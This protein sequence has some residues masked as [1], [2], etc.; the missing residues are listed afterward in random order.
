MAV[1]T[2]DVIGFRRIFVLFVT[3][4]LLPAM[5]MSGFA[6]VAIANQHRSDQQRQR[7]RGEEGLAKAEAAFAATI[8]AADQ[9]MREAAVRSPQAT[10]PLS[11]ASVVAAGHPVGA[12]AVLNPQG[13][14]VGG[15]PPL[16]PLQTGL[17]STDQ[18]LKALADSLRPGQALQLDMDTEPPRLISAQRTHEGVTVF[19]EIDPEALREAVQKRVKLDEGNR[20][21]I[22]VR[23]QK[24]SVGSLDQWLKPA[25]QPGGLE[26][27][28]PVVVI[29]QRRLAAPFDRVSFLIEGAPTGTRTTTVVMVMLVV[30]F[31]TLLT[32]GVVL[33][34]R[35]IWQE[36]KL[37]RLK[38]DFVSHVSHELR[39]P[40][41]SIRM[42]IETL[43][44]GRAQNADEEAECLELL[45]RETERLSEMIERV[46]GY[47]R[48]QS[49]R[50]AFALVPVSAEE[51]I[52][53]AI[54]AFRAQLIGR[55]A[56]DLELRT[57]V[58]PDLPPV[59]ADPEAM[60]EALLNLIGNAYK[61]TGAKKRIC[62]YAKRGRRRVVLGVLDN[63][64]GL[65]KSEHGRI[66]DRF[67]QAGNLLTRKSKGSG[68][69]LAITRG[70]VE[71]Q[72]GRIFVQSEEGQGS[73]FYIELK[74]A[75]RSLEEA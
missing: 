33:T 68:L 63:G 9:A 62:V 21:V 58:E 69:G 73:D 47:A 54:A 44:L 48:L 29:A 51:L 50:R 35:L 49:G 4:V 42:F 70:I 7:E 34:S 60:T 36:A 14:L 17:L 41:T 74:E 5:L 18:K 52:D 15:V 55:P 75:P 37:S 19:Y 6:V 20:L 61:Y 66:F 32:I 67:Y 38:T 11:V 13:E 16:T 46:L 2:R 64:P 45:G 56:A 59:L 72:G 53:D 57:E 24:M 1:T 43:R 23:S 12:W 28:S 3:L 31:Y 71:G 39:T 40:L 30:L 27:E 8:D 65:P 26:A 10:L 22:Q 25:A